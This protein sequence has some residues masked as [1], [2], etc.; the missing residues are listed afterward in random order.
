MWLLILEGLSIGCLLGLTGAGGGILAVPALML[1]QSWSIQQAAPVGL[2]AITISALVGTIEGLSHKIVRYRAALWI[3]LISIPFAHY[4]VQLSHHLPTTWLSGG[5]GLVMLIVAYRIFF[6]HVHDIQ[7]PPCKINQR[8][9][10]LIWNFKTASILGTLGIITGTLTGLLG[11]GGGFIIVPALRKVTNLSSK[12]IVA[13]SLMIIASI[14]CISIAMHMQQGFHYPLTTTASFVIACMVGML[15]GRQLI[16]SISIYWV[17]RIFA[18]TVTG[19][20]V[21]LISS[22]I[23]SMT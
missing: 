10:R 14:G 21:Y 9:G 22:A 3:A 19:V 17:Q 4:G 20:S 23:Q 11:V 1:S 5:F 8:T 13:T 15:V 2:L 7:N 6:N 16:R 12:S 18:C